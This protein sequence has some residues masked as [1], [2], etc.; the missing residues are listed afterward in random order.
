MIHLLISITSRHLVSNTNGGHMGQS[1]KAKNII[2]GNPL[3]RSAQCLTLTEKRLL[4]LAVAKMSG[5]NQEITISAEEYAD[6]YGLA[7]KE[8]YDSLKNGC[9]QI[10]KRDI[11]MQ[12][13]DK[14]AKG[15]E[16]VW[17]GTTCWIQGYFYNKGLGSVKFKFSDYVH[18]YLFDLSKEFTKYRL[19]QA[20]SL[21]SIHS[22]R[23]LELLEQQKLTDKDG[24]RWLKISV[25]E[26]HHAFEATATYK[27]NFSVFSRKTIEPAIKELTLKDNW[28]IEW[29]A[30]KRG[31]KVG[32]LHFKFKKNEQLGFDF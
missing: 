25:D 4:M 21:R 7:V 27:A 30:I 8:T 18:P 6:C 9:R 29:E 3:V 31:R 5:V 14:D 13:K 20:A 24:W 19:Q 28:L 11:F 10:A 2:M 17:E 32:M 23:L 15:R 12:F 1:L 26:A 22:W 16:R